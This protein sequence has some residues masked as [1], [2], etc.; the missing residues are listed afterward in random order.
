[1][2]NNTTAHP[3]PSPEWLAQVNEPAMQP[4]QVIIDPHHHLW[5]RPGYPY[6]LHDFLADQACGHRIVST[7]YVQARSMY[8]ASGDPLL[9]PVGETEFD[10]KC[11]S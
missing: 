7:V 4:E 11:D 6:L 8:R 10:F 5:D 3:A 1:M 9:S 2:H